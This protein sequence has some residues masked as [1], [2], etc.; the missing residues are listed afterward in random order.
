MDRRP[1]DRIE[2]RLTALDREIGSLG[3]CAW[4]KATL[5]PEVRAAAA[6]DPERHLALTRQLDAH[7][8]ECTICRTRDEIIA[9]MD[10]ALDD[11]WSA[12]VQR[13]YRA[14]FRRLPV[15]LQPAVAGGVLMGSLAVPNA[16]I[17]G[18]QNRSLAWGTSVMALSIGIGTAAGLIGGNAY[19]LLKPKEEGRGIVGSMVAGTLFILSITVP[20]CLVLMAIPGTETTFGY[21]GMGWVAAAFIVMTVGPTLGLAWFAEPDRKLP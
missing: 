5:T 21:G 19:R 2:S 16:I 10:Q 13:R 8:M 3:T 11:S 6:G 7:A 1:A 20:T 14:W 4:V 9:R 12:Q 17:F 18:L 15:W